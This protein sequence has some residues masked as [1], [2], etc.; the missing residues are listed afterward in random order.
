M[1]EL[2]EISMSDNNSNTAVTGQNLIAQ[3]AVEEWHRIVT[4][5]DWGKLANLLA[6]DVTYHNP[7]Q[8]EPYRGKDALVGILRLVFSIFEDFEYRRRFSGENAYALEFSAS[9]GESQLSGVD[10]VRFDSAGKMTELIVMLRPADVVAKLGQEAGRRMAE[11]N[12]T[13]AK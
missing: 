11:A 2:A 7:A 8:Y 12:R 13:S 10:L 6:D 5:R 1:L 3:A 9:V 4:Q